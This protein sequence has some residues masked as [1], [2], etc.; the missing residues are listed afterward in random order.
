MGLAIAL[1]LNR[2]MRGRNLLRTIVFVP[3]VLAEVVAGVIWRQ[4][5]QADYGLL[6]TIL[7]S[8]SA[9]RLRS[10]AS[11]ATRTTRSVPSWWC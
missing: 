2:K 1:L 3:Y 11:W 5:L 7:T 8:A 6:D 9:S 4:M 10:R